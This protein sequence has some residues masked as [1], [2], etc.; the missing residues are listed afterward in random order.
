MN[1]VTTIKTIANNTSPSP[2]WAVTKIACNRSTI[3]KAP[4]VIWPKTAQPAIIEAI[5]I[6][7][8]AAFDFNTNTMVAITSSPVV[9]AIDL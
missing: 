5:F 7:L 3:T 8:E 6:P 4:S 9:A 1:K 2:R